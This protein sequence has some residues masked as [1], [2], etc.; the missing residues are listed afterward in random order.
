[1]AKVNRDDI[2]EAAIRLFNQNG[3]HATSMQDVARAVDIKK[4]SLYHHFES[5]E[6]ILLTI[7][8]MG[9]DRLI[10]ELESI[11]RSERDSASKLRDAIQTHASA[12]AQNPSGA[13]IFFRED[14]GLGDDY[15]AHYVERRDHFERL[16]RLIVQEGI[17]RGQFRTNDVAIT[18]QAI[19]GTINWMTRWYRPAGR[20]SAEQIADQFSDLFV[21]GL[22]SR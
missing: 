5:K 8:E 7:L 10:S 15:L 11:A 16:F 6:A 18:V 17:D 14:R 2:L 4:P 12:I 22:C 21:D 9:M 20:L 3:Y 1:M 19:L 13:A